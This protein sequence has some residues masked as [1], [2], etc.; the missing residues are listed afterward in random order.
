MPKPSVPNVK[1]NLNREASSLLHFKGWLM[2]QK[3]GKFKGFQKRYFVL[4]DE[5]LRYYKSQNDTT[6]QAILSLNHYRLTRVEETEGSHR[7]FLFALSSDDREKYDWPD[8]I[9]QA[10][11]ESEREHWLYHLERQTADRSVLDKW[12]ERLD[13]PDQST[14]RDSF[15][16]ESNHSLPTL[17][18]HEEDAQSVVSSLIQPRS[19]FPL[20]HHPSAESFPK[21]HQLTTT[22]LDHTRKGSFRLFWLDAFRPN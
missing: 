2:K 11:S 10:E 19:F 20:R 5:E 15:Y 8:Y 7:P 22:S 14:A 9:L 4:Y 18:R 12:L 3:H 17:S 6:A 1:H 13:V 21:H 16:S